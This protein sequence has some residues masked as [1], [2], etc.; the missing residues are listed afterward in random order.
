MTNKFLIAI[1]CYNEEQNLDLLL[2]ELLELNL[3][4]D[5]LFVED[6]SIDR[7][8]EIINK[9]MQ[10]SVQ[11]ISLLKHCFNLGPG[12]AMETAFKYAISNDYDYV[13]QLD[14]DGQHDP[15]AITQIMN[16]FNQD[17]TIDIAII[18][19][20][21]GQPSYKMSLLRKIGHW[22]Y[23]TLA[24]IISGQKITDTTSGFRGFSIK[25]CKFLI[26][27]GY[28]DFFPDIDIILLLH[29]NGFKIKEIPGTMRPRKHGKSMYNF[30]RVIFH[31]FRSFLSLSII[32][33]RVLSKKG[34]LK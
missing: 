34:R 23:S 19:R 9:S 24:S 25:S 5:I 1:P 20:F 7:S 21:L 3:K 31:V 29:F 6:G 17:K 22:L 16:V 14:S 8:A 10:N 13:I 27:T 15:R 18:S 32:V 4:A 33:W 12:V 30:S 2:S 26:A 11:P 28:P